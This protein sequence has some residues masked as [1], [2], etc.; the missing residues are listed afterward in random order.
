MSAYICGIIYILV[1][2]LTYIYF[3]FNPQSRIY[4]SNTNNTF[5]IILFHFGGVSIS[6]LFYSDKC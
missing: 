6:I 2:K 5:Y 4:F 1:V 3:R